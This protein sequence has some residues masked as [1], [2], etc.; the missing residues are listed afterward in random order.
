MNNHRH[1]DFPVL[2][3]LLI[4]ILVVSA[5]IEGVFIALFF[6]SVAKW[7][8]IGCGILSV[9]GL[10]VW[11]LICWKVRKEMYNPWHL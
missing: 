5:L 7:H 4:F 2:M 1:S 3:F 11:P 9:L 6:L 10:V 8:S